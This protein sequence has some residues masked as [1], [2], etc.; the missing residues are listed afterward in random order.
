MDILGAEFTGI[1]ICNTF[2]QYPTY[3]LC[4]TLEAGGCR[5]MRNNGEVPEMDPHAMSK[6]MNS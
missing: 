6:D 3:D 2:V 5:N 1:S 4:L